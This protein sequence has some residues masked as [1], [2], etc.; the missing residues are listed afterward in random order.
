MNWLNP[1]NWFKTA[2]ASL[3]DA[4]VDEYVTVPKGKE[5]IIDATN[6]ALAYSETRWTDD[7]CRVFSRGL[8]LAG[9]AL[10]DLGEAIN[11]EGCDGRSVSLEEFEAILVDAQAA[12]GIIVTDEM[13]EQWRASIKQSFRKQLGIA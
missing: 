3:C 13:A 9:K 2:V 8:K 5:L 10:T 1:I 7:E 12:F 11:P 6:M 4:K